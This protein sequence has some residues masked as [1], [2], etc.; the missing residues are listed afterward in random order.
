MSDEN[1]LG[2]GKKL[3]KFWGMWNK[4]WERPPETDKDAWNAF[5]EAER[6]L[7]LPEYRSHKHNGSWFVFK[8]SSPVPAGP[9]DR[10]MVQERWDMFWKALA[11][12]HSVYEEM[13]P[14]EDAL[15]VY[16]DRGLSFNLRKIIHD[17]PVLG[18]AA[19]ADDDMRFAELGETGSVIGS[20]IEKILAAWISL[21]QGF[22]KKLKGIKSPGGKKSSRYTHLKNY[23]KSDPKLATS[24]CQSARHERAEAGRRALKSV[25][26]HVFGDNRDKN[27]LAICYRAAHAFLRSR[28]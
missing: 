1:E 27:N 22:D 9:Y 26:V 6:K 24:I 16:F 15:L 4:D 8:G 21:Q 5:W 3:R 28:N 17:S 2:D 25:R 23:F 12:K 20:I 11:W 14:H 10:P 19:L 7:P 13:R 18:L